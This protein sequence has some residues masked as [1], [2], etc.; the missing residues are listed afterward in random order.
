[1]SQNHT[2][3]SKY[4]RYC[5]SSLPSRGQHRIDSWL[6]RRFSL[7]KHFQPDWTKMKKIFLSSS[8]CNLQLSWLVSHL[9]LQKFDCTLKIQ[10]I[11][12][13]KF[14]WNR[15]RTD[16]S[17]TK[18]CWH[19]QLMTMPAVEKGHSTPSFW[20][21]EYWIRRGDLMSKSYAQNTHQQSCTL[22]GQNLFC[23]PPRNRRQPN[24]STQLPSICF[25]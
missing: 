20:S 12:H 17:R 13:G 21:F 5:R 6:E 4:C 1:M 9:D 23:M 24:L 16:S 2:K 10:Q 18:H 14:D 19:R 25:T 15:S 11:Y 7:V 3:F 8:R 22:L